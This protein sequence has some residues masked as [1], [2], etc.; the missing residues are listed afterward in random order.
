MVTG[1]ERGLN[2]V[3]KSY[4]RLQRATRGYRWLPRVKSGYIGLDYQLTIRV[5]FNS[6]TPM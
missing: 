4:R 3:K 2:G 5:Q 1:G 6:K